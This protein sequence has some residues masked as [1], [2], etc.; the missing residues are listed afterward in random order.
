M[1]DEPD[2]RILDRALAALIE[3]LEGTH[4]VAALTAHPY[5][6]DAE[7]SWAAPPVTALPY[8]GDVPADVAA[9]AAAR[10]GHTPTR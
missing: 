2:S 7:L 4:E 8:D 10:R 5:D 1:L 9:L 3:V 6:D